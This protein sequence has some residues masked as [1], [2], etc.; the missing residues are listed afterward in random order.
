MVREAIG[1]IGGLEKMGVKGSTV[2]VKPNVVSGEPSPATTSPEVV[3][4]IVKLLRDAGAKKVYVG[5][6][7][8]LLTLPTR[9]NM[10]KTGILRATQEAGAEALRLYGKVKGLYTKTE[11]PGDTVT[12]LYLRDGEA[13]ATTA[14]LGVRAD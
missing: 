9:R 5:D 13:L 1:M 10:E 11:R 14:T 4:A 3:K 2:L 6:M 7:S 8:A 12:V